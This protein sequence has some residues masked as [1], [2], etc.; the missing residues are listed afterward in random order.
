MHFTVEAQR[1]IREHFQSLSH[2]HFL[3]AVDGTTGNGHDTAFL[4]DLVGESGRVLAID[5]QASAIAA[6]KQKLALLERVDRVI[7]HEGCHSKLAQIM[8]IHNLFKID[9]AMFNLGYLPYS[10]RTITTQAVSSLAALQT[11][12]QWLRPNGIIS[13]ICYPAHDGGKEEHQTLSQ[14]IKDLKSFSAPPKVESYIDLN[15][16]KSPQFWLIRK[17][18]AKTM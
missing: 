16:P 3:I 1:M 4:A 18:N 10:D 12:W 2:S 13:I 9:V 14:W 17:F 11:A 5:V 15:Q 6:A 7:W 8:R